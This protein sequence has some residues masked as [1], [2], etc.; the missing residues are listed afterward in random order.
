MGRWSCASAGGCSTTRRTRRTRSRP[1]S[2]CWPTGPA[3]SGGGTRSVAGSSA[4]R[5]GS[6]PRPGF[7][8][9]R[10]A[11]EKHVAEQTPEAYRPTE[12]IGESEALFEE[13]DRLPERLRA[14]VV[15]CYLEGLT[16]DAAAQRLGVSE[17]S[18]RGRLARAREQLR[19]RLT[20]RGV[21][22]PAGFLAGAGR[23]PAVLPVSLVDSTARIA[24]GV[25]AG[26]AAA[27]LARG[28]LH[29]MFLGHLRTAAAVLVAVIGSGLMAWHALAARDDDKGRP[30]P[31]PEPARAAA[32]PAP[33]QAGDDPDRKYAIT[34]RVSVEGTN[35]PVPGAR[36]VVDLGFGGRNPILGESQDSSR[37]IRTGADG[38]FR[39][40]IPA[41]Y[42]SIGLFELPPGYFRGKWDPSSADVILSR[43][44]PVSRKD[45]V[46][47]RGTTWDFRV[48]GGSGGAGARVYFM[49]PTRIGEEPA[50]A[51]R[52]DP[53]GTAILT[54]PPDSRKLTGHVSGD[55]ELASS[56]NLGLEWETG[57]RPAAVRSIARDPERPGAS[58]SPTRAGS[59]PC[60]G[61]CPGPSRLVPSAS[62]LRARAR[63]SSGPT[64]SNR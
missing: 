1:R 33:G 23:V 19:R 15:L 18:V 51:V 5:S 32:S 49:N 4:S 8:P 21:G 47:R 63:P 60:S 31:Q 9:R 40:E 42:A 38:R 59:R 48:S 58:T 56:I 26:E 25:Q 6:P 34:G 62:G 61:R 52:S 16:Y 14:A 50:F 29:S 46:V 64:R 24:L 2:W 12:E 30:I 53:S 22:L 3:R 44:S 20:D 11:G 37:D 28:V 17:G 35:E 43:E 13:I 41:G 57:F 54:L 45:Y 39:V 7:A 55:G 27:A 36:L 10:R